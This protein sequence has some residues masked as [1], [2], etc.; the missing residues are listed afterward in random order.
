MQQCDVNR[1][2]KRVHGAAAFEEVKKQKDALKEAEKRRKEVVKKQKHA[3]VLI[4]VG[5]LLIIN[6]IQ[7]AKLQQWMENHVPKQRRHLVK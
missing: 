2:F 4:V 1:Q 5:I 3:I 7:F 6:V